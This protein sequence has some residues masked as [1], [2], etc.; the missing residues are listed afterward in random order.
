MNT[1]EPNN[2]LKHDKASLP[3]GEKPEDEPIEPWRYQTHA[4]PGI[5]WAFA[6]AMAVGFVVAFAVGWL[7]K[8]R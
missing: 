1:D 5:S 3:Y 8:M 6:G 7:L 4:K 2:R